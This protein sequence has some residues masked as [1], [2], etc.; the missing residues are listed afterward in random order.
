MPKRHRMDGAWGRS[1]SAVGPHAM[2]AS[3][4]RRSER[5]TSVLR[6]IWAIRRGGEEDESQRRGQSLP[7]YSLGRD[8]KFNGAMLSVKI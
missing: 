2:Q 6:E 3:S 5:A 8:S 7:R 4:T 1:L